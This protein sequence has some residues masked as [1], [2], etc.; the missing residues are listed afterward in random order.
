MNPIYMAIIA[1]N[2]IEDR[3]RSARLHRTA[4]VV[5]ARPREDRAPRRRGSTIL[6]SPRET[7]ILT[8]LGAT[9]RTEAAAI[10]RRQ[11]LLGAP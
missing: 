4:R 6:E 3:T 2:T 1:G 9:N 8:K 11:A 5:R 7:R 10:A